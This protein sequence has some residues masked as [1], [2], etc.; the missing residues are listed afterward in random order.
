MN[1]DDK[2]QHDI[3]FARQAGIVAGLFKPIPNRHING[4]LHLSIDKAEQFIRE[5]GL[6]DK[7]TYAKLAHWRT[8]KEYSHVGPSW[9][10][11]NGKV[12]YPQEELLSWCEK[13]R[14]EGLPLK[15]GRGSVNYGTGSSKQ[16][17]QG[18]REP[19]L[20]YLMKKIEQ[21]KNLKAIEDEFDF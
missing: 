1:D 3:A 11:Y 4:K 21:A 5:Q 9:T 7:V 12:Y 6:S 18:K 8:R 16:R 17:K 13:V 10:K 19:S 14:V 2:L 20:T 15:A